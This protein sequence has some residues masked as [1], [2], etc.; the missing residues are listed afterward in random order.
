EKSGPIGPPH[1]L[2][3]IKTVTELPARSIRSFPSSPIPPLGVAGDPDASGELNAE[4]P[5]KAA[6]V[7]P[8]PLN[9]TS[10]GSWFAGTT[11]VALFTSFDSPYTCDADETLNPD[12]ID[13]VTGFPP[14][15]VASFALIT[16]VTSVRPSFLTT[17]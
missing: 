2:R 3:I 12:G 11:C 6:P 8:S 5:P 1:P 13:S 16:V 14:T 10:A 7:S 17:V 15:E 4:D 9:G